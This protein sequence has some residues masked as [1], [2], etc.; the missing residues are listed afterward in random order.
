MKKL[1]A[2][3]PLCLLAAAAAPA[4]TASPPAGNG[5]YGPRQGEPTLM[6][7]RLATARFRDVNAALAEGYVRDPGDACIAAADMGLPAAM[8]GMGIHFFR[9]DLLGIAGP[10]NP[11]VGG[12]G[13]HT[14]FS[15]PAILLYEPRADGTLELVGVENLV[16]QA[17]W[18]AAG[19]SAPPS[20][21]GRQW[22]SMADDP[23]TPAD[24]AHGFEPHFDQHIWLWRDNPRGTY[25]S[26]NPA[27]T[28]AHHRS[29][30]AGHAAHGGH[31][32]R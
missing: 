23:A 22:D 15:R 3:L 7:M 24:E 10:P 29:Q 25:E 14:D 20:I 12:S 8:G 1:L 30:N 6:E 32:G 9:P 18:R 16:F 31:G 26:F 21:H 13:T 17:A 19:H 28:C 5:S 27:V 2:A 4:S 11:R